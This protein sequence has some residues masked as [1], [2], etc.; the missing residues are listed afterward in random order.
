MVLDDKGN[1]LTKIDPAT[2][3]KGETV[4]VADPYNLYF[5]PD[6]Q[7]AI[8]VAESLHR[9]DFRDAHTMSLKYSL[10]VPCEWRQPYGLFG[11]RPLPDRQLRIRRKNAQ[12]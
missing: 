1:G 8:V 5:T 7:E 9:L 3:K 10:T 12:D 2:G 11:R 6:G 4:P